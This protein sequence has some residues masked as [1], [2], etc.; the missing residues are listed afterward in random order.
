MHH[1]VGVA[2]LRR[3][4]FRPLSFN[5]DLSRVSSV[6]HLLQ[7][8]EDQLKELLLLMFVSIRHIGISAANAGFK[9]GRRL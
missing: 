9:E 6:I 3:V 1:S 4:L 5:Q 2:A 7:P 8:H